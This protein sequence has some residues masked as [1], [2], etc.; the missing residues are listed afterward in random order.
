MSTRTI[1]VDSKVY[2]RLAAAKREGESFSK[3]IG[4]LLSTA[5]G[6]HTGDAI[7]RELGAL[8]A[9]SPGEA[10]AFY[11]AVTE[12]RASESWDSSDLR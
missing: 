3:V 11:A 8:P 5:A 7:Q 2:D 12:N 6:A 9:L 1:A 4:R 10:E